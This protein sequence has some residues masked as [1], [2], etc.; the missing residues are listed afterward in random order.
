MLQTLTSRR[1][2]PL[3]CKY[4]R[5]RR[6]NVAAIA[7]GRDV[8]SALLQEI[9]DHGRKLEHKQI[10]A[11]ID[12]LPLGAVVDAAV[13]EMK[14]DY[15][16]FQA[17]EKFNPKFHACPTSFSYMLDAFVHM[18]SMK[19]REMIAFTKVETILADHVGSVSLFNACCLMH[20]LECMKS[21]SIIDSIE[22]GVGTQND[23]KNIPK[24]DR[25]RH[26]LPLNTNPI[27]REFILQYTQWLLHMN[28]SQRY[29]NTVNIMC[30]SNEN[31]SRS[32]YFT[33]Q[34]QYLHDELCFQKKNG[35]DCDFTAIGDVALAGFT[36]ARMFNKV[37]IAVKRMKNYLIDKNYI[38]K[39]AFSSAIY[40]CI[41]GKAFEHDTLNADKK[42]SRPALD[43]L[44]SVTHGNSFQS[45]NLR[46]IFLN[47]SNQ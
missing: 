26:S 16:S 6:L 44:L 37:D 17:G 21:Q 11:K 5:Y 36:A 47:V 13:L 29:H 10:F 33:N 4:Q 42:V 43:A 40:G 30:K 25:R 35:I 32:H 34:I 3:F 45:I 12:C 39:E 8:Y 7:Q 27:E 23:S 1:V 9:V 41:T 28:S 24:D 15:P 14:R 22:A 38:T 31:L 20:E 2:G 19:V 46:G 18:K